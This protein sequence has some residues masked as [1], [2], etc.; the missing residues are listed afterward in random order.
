MPDDPPWGPPVP[1][2]APRFRRGRLLVAAPTLVDPNFARTVVLMLE[3]SGEGAL[4]VVLNRPMTLRVHDVVPPPLRDLMG[5]DALV[6]AGGP[7]QPEAVLVLADHM[8]PEEAATLVVH[9]VGIVD[10]H[11]DAEHLPSLLR[12]A[13]A[14]GG[15]AGWSEGQLEEEI[16]Q[17][18]WID[19]GCDVDDVFTS[20]PSGLWRRVL[21]RKGGTYR[22]IAQMPDHP[23]LN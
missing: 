7:V 18:A 6:H 5:D 2:D 10:P 1:D 20:E 13:R 23:E 3:H 19:A 9:G 4:G 21:E 17:G 14:F 11:A 12:A 15:Y 8:L 22:L 16:A